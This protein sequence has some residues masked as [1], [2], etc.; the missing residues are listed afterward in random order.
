MEILIPVT[1]ILI[2]S[3]FYALSYWSPK[4][5]VLLYGISAIL[6][7]L[8]GVL[9]VIGY[10]EVYMGSHT[11]LVEETQLDSET[12]QYEITKDKDTESVPFLALIP[13]IFVL[14]SIYQFTVIATTL[15]DGR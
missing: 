13:I 7:L 5:D 10:N 15:K 14:F 11:I 1:I 2:A 6:F 4:T 9:G 8:A 12:T 3:L